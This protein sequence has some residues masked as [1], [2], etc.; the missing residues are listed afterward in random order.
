[1]ECNVKELCDLQSKYSVIYRLLYLCFTQKS[2]S[3]SKKNNYRYF[4]LY[5][6]SIM[7][8]EQNSILDL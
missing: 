2:P 4:S 5:F 8:N 1:M 3:T 6:N 7:V